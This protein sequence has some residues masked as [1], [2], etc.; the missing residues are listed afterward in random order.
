[1][2]SVLLFV[3]VWG[4]EG[5]LSGVRGGVVQTT[6]QKQDCEWEEEEQERHIRVGASH[7]LLGPSLGHGGDHPGVPGLLRISW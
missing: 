6:S 3:C 1:M 7:D 4:G 2:E 5:A